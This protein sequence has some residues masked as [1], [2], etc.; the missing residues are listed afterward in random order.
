MSLK[1]RRRKMNRL[2]LMSAP[3]L[4]KVR[5]WWESLSFMEKYRMCSKPWHRES[6]TE[7]L[8]EVVRLYGKRNRDMKTAGPE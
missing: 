6:P 2:R 1:T 7:F 3:R 5:E 8:V 4:M